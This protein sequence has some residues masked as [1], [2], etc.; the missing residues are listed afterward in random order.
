MPADR[1]DHIAIVLPGLR[2]GGSEHVVSTIANHWVSCGHQVTIVTF[3]A[4]NAVPYYTFDS[5]IR[6]I[7]LGLSSELTSAPN[8]AR[9]ALRR[10][11]ALRKTLKFIAPGVIVSFLRRTNIVALLAT[12]GL[13]IPVIVSER[14]N[15][16]LQPLGRT[17]ST[18]R[19][20]LYP[21]AF[22]LVTMTSGAMNYFPPSMRRRSWVIPNPVKLPEGLRR[23]GSGKRLTAVGRLVPQKGFDQLI[24]A[25]GLIAQKYP[26]WTLTIWGEGPDRKA[27]EKQRK[28]LGLDDRIHMPGISKRPGSWLETA[29]AFVLS[30]RFE[31]WGIVLLEAMAWGLPCVAFNCQWGPSEMI[32]SGVN[33]ILV[34]PGN[35]PALGEALS[36]VMGNAELA[37]RLAKAAQTSTERFSH[38]RVMSAWDDVIDAALNKQLR[39]GFDQSFVSSSRIKLAGLTK[40]IRIADPSNEHR[41]GVGFKGISKSNVKSVIVRFLCP[42]VALY[43]AAGV[44]YALWN[45]EAYGSREPQFIRYIAVPAVLCALFAL[46]AI[47]LPRRTVEHVNA[48]VA[49]VVVAAFAAQFVLSTSTFMATVDM[50]DLIGTAEADVVETSIPPD[51][52]LDRVNTRA[53]VQ[54][55]DQALL[56]GI[57]NVPVVMC[58]SAEGPVRYTADR[59]GFNNPDSIHDVPIDVAIV[60]DAFVEG[61][62]LKPGFDFVSLVRSNHAETANLGMRGNGPLF[63]LAAIG[64]FGPIIRP[65]TV[66]LAFFEGNDLNDLA[67]GL[68]MPWLRTVLD[69]FPD[70]G[71]DP[72]PDHTLDAARNAIESYK[73]KHR[74]PIEMLLRTH[75]VRNFLAL[76]D[77]GSAF[78]ISYPRVTP[79]PETYGQILARARDITAS[80]GG[81]VAIVYIPRANRFL[82]LFP[83]ERAY[84][85]LRLDVLSVAKELDIDIIDL[86]PTFQQ[87]EQPLALYA[88]DSHFSN[89]GATLAAKAVND[90]LANQ[91]H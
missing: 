75:F 48:C 72:V 60:G 13:G 68:E 39:G 83:P 35:V 47:L 6:I 11:W 9:L 54:S 31:G 2:A 71:R 12:V 20:L 10:V 30:S 28:E 40:F 37:N 46:C 14:N 66:L 77:I 23:L 74:T 50:I 49:T 61:A 52:A 33:G 21:R 63:E 22:G 43:F 32:E 62:C 55:L 70:F 36:R 84:D 3:E 4:E 18:L 86:T 91:I 79:V 59:Y 56:G 45:F 88:P 81:H 65:K 90:Y 80:W 73:E 8:G 7:N 41:R 38:A 16:A 78:G 24:V 29:D 58:V 17:W 69:R 67:D 27:L 51:L 34:P 19:Q 53:G 42:M 76:E 5:K 26:D 44:G 15:P 85:V 89:E 87:Q 64:R 82:G 1:H 25:F 57:P